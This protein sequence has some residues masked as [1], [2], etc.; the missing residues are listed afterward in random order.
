MI[1]IVIVIVI[2]IVEIAREIVTGSSCCALLLQGL[3]PLLWH[4]GNRDCVH[5]HTGTAAAEAEAG[6]RSAVP[7]RRPEKGRR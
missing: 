6:T 5:C 3:V 7:A 4:H 1:A 2:V